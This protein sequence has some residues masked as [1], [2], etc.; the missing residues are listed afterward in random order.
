MSV[1]GA[2]VGIDLG[3]TYSC[4][5]VWQ[6]D[7]VEIIAN[8][9]GNAYGIKLLDVD[10]DGDLDIIGLTRGSELKL[11]TNEG[12]GAFGS[13][14]TIGSGFNSPIEFI[15]ADLTG[16]GHEDLIVRSVRVVIPDANQA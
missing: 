10:S 8:D 13:A 5:G 4:V 9:Q 6:N 16:N 7:R 12:G 14:M 11:F 1:E 3:T 15:T 2:S